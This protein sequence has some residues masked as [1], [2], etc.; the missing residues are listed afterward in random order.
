MPSMNSP[1]G[2][3]SYLNVPGH[4]FDIEAEALQELASGKRVL[5]IG[6][7]YGRSTVAMAYS[8]ASVTTVE[9]FKGDSQIGAPDKAK[10]L[11]YLRETGAFAKT[12]LVDA[13]FFASAKSGFLDLR[14]FD[15]FFYDGPHLP[16]LYE[17]Q[18]FEMLL[19]RPGPY[20]V[21]IHDY[22]PHDPEFAPLVAAA[23][24]FTE[25]TGT[26]MQGDQS[27]GSVRWW[28]VAY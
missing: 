23:K 20:T 17:Q 28:E 24:W 1:L 10:T 7:H 26:K 8:A 9:W 3:E 25:Q 18:F 2:P 27:H 16:P 11:E 12:K 4:L 15:F 6:T 22:K 21:A 14:K 5:E 19:Q 13:D